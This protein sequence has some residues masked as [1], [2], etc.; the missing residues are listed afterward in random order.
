MNNHLSNIILASIN[1][2]QQQQKH[3]NR[4]KTK[5]SLFGENNSH[6]TRTLLFSRVNF[7]SHC[8]G[9]GLQ[10][11]DWWKWFLQT[12]FFEISLPSSSGTFILKWSLYIGLGNWPLT[13][14]VGILTCAVIRA[15]DS[16]RLWGKKQKHYREMWLFVCPL[17]LLSSKSLYWES[18]LNSEGWG[19]WLY[20]FIFLF[21]CLF[22]ISYSLFVLKV[23]TFDMLSAFG[24]WQWLSFFLVRIL[25]SLIA[26]VWLQNGM[27]KTKWRSHYNI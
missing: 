11:P 12:C 14:R 5:K 20:C 22:Q 9:D 13:F 7:F 26:K 18:D 6:P 25:W 3:C 19:A 17:G 4:K 8:S 1:P 16:Q 10:F 2:G 23:S 24:L 27:C 15:I 21:F